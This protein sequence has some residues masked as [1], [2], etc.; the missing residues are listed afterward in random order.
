MADRSDITLHIHTPLSPQATTEFLNLAL[1]C[2]GE[3]DTDRP[4]NTLFFEGATWGILD[5]QI[6]DWLISH[7]VVAH[8]TVE[9]IDGICKAHTVILLADGKTAV[10]NGKTIWVDGTSQKRLHKTIGTSLDAQIAKHFAQ[11]RQTLHSD[12]HGFLM[13]QTRT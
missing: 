12:H 2:D 11:N 7:S 10:K 5:K 4:Q 8:W 3:I 6:V 9:A 13:A 1:S